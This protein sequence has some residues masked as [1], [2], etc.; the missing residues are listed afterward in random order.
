VRKLA[1]TVGACSAALFLGLAWPAFFRL[2]VP[3]SDIG[4]FHVPMRYLYQQAL[5]AGDSLLWTPSVFAGFYIHGEGQLG[6]FHPLHQLV[7]RVLPL[8]LAFNVQILASYA[9]GFA[10]MYWLLRRL[11]LSSAAS[12]FGAMV[13]GFCGFQVLHY[14]H[15]NAVAVVAH[16]PWLLACLDLVIV[17]EHP[18][19][20]AAGYAGVAI[21]IASELL[22]GF[23]QGVWWN[24]LA[25][26]PFACWRAGDTGRWRALVPCALAVLTGVL[27]GGVQLLPSIDAAM[28]SERGRQ[29]RS[30]FLGYSLHP[31]NVSQFV[32]PYGLAER[33]FSPAEPLEVHEQGIYPGAFLVIA[34]IWLWIRRRDLTRRRT[35]IVGASC[36][37]AVMFVL[38]LGRF[39]G[40]AILLTYLP[41]IG[42]LRAP[43]RYI[44][45]V[46][47]VLAIF[48][49]IAFDDLA[50]L[51]NGGLRLRRMQIA[52]LAGIASAGVAMTLLL[53]THIL[54]VRA[55]MIFGPV[56]R[57]LVGNAMIVSVTLA[58]VLAARGVAWALPLLA[59]ITALDL[60][61]WGIRHIHRERPQPIAWF[62]GGIPPAPSG[63]PVR[64]VTPLGWGN[65][66][67]LKNYQLAIGY[68]GLYPGTRIS[69]ERSPVFPRLAGAQLEFD[70]NARI[71]A[72]S[73][74]VAR[75]RLLVDVRV[76]DNVARDVEGLDLQQTALLDHPV[77]PL[78]GPAG[79]ALV[80]LDRPGHLVVETTAPGRQLL[81]VS[82]RFHEGWSVSEQG[83]ALDP[84]RV[85]GD[86]LG[87][88]LE[89]GTHRVEFRFGPASF[90]FGVIASAAGLLALLAG[91]VAMRRSNG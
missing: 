59:I 39:G 46:Q 49:A 18:G 64:V 13:F 43:A 44:V 27:L 10:G 54:P 26:L 87:V 58:L 32:S 1:W 36:F 53:N 68:V 34:P 22:V 83:R 35:L 86:F 47:F 29:P 31:W 60:G 21:V 62:T 30:F 61:M 65:T 73:D 5:Q 82:E 15:V 8:D 66:L 28:H 67:L 41:G 16:L 80:T 48:A 77:A 2:I 75:A 4:T 85:N 56:G 69:W 23:P 57:A 63:A 11:Q 72:V 50:V 55:D 20:R 51:R 52:Q 70:G 14:P 45:L 19:R 12:L 38:A 74:S 9:W 71:S 37:A 81:S 90:R 33:V 79:T 40:V 25:A 42:S 17:A 3:V 88:V 6:A 91:V 76:T 89:P 84:V 24:L 7:Y 78:S